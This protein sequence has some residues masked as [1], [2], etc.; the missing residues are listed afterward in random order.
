MKKR[1]LDVAFKEGDAVP[2]DAIVARLD[3]RDIESKLESKRRELDVLDA[4]TRSQQERVRLAQTTWERDVAARRAA[5]DQAV[6][7]ADLAERTYKR[8]RDLVAKGA[9]TAQL[10]DDAR[11]RRDQ[12]ASGLA[13]AREL[14]A[15]A[16]AE[17]AGIAVAEQTLASMREKHG[18]LLAQIAELEVMR[19][20]YDVRAPSVATVVQT[21]YIWPGELAQPGAP[22]LSV[23]DPADKYVQVYVPVED[24]DRFRIGRRV[25]IELDSMPG[26]RFPGEISFIADQANFTPE[27]IETR[28][29]RVG[30]VYRAKV[31]VLE[32]AERLQPGT[33]GDVYFASDEAGPAPNDG[34]H[35]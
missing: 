23:L 20:K 5:V 25:E 3:A 29:D 35:E 15:R 2:A 1:V 30:Q 28:S 33:E 34:A 13:S 8:E 24:L 4:E 14:F 32:G 6:S 22:T 18:L 11:A 10:L 21:Q 12:A 26:T 9:S 17:Q 19:S 31:R 7:A 16:E 27:K